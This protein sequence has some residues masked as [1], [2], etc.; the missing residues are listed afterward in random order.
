LQWMKKYILFPTLALAREFYWDDCEM[1][2]S[3]EL[4]YRKRKSING[5]EG[6]VEAISYMKWG[7]KSVNIFATLV[8]RKS[9]QKIIFLTIIYIY[10]HQYISLCVYNYVLLKTDLEIRRK[11]FLFVCFLRWSLDM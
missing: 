7:L 2:Q 5:L 4:K 11:E 1:K 8:Q 10:M 6:R 3:S 9:S